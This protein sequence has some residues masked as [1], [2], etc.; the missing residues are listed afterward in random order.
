MGHWVLEIDGRD[1]FKEE[2][3]FDEDVVFEVKVRYRPGVMDALWKIKSMSKPLS[4]K[5]KSELWDNLN[6]D[7][8]KLK[9]V[10]TPKNIGKKDELEIKK[11]IGILEGWLKEKR[12]DNNG[13]YFEYR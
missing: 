3:V 4:K 9:W 6:V 7:I 8:E 11:M 5:F 13:Q 10:E 12:N 2:M 1:V